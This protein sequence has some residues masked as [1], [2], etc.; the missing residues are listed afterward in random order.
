M[1]SLLVGRVVFV[2]AAAAFFG[3]FA[4]MILYTPV[5]DGMIHLKRA[6]E[7]STFVREQDTG[8]HHIKAESLNMAIYTQGFA[9]AQDRMWQMEKARRMAKG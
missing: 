5:R 8:I 9:H 3:C 2:A 6:N 1:L 4:L 7:A